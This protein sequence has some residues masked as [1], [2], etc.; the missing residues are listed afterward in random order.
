MVADPPEKHL[1]RHALI[2]SVQ[3]LFDE[4]GAGFSGR[5]LQ[6]A[7]TVKLPLGSPEPVPRAFAVSEDLF[8]KRG[9]TS[10]AYG[11]IRFLPAQSLAP[12]RDD[13][14]ACA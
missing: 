13:A 2:D 11:S 1:R 9:N 5:E 10:K 6:R 8:S 3:Q 4:T 14:S 12:A 7:A